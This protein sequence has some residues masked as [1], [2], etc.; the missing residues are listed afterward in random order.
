MFLCQVFNCFFA[1]FKQI[2]VRRKSTEKTI[3][4]QVL[5]AVKVRK[6]TTE[7]R[8]KHKST[9]CLSSNIRP[10]SI[11]R[12]CSNKIPPFD[13]YERIKGH[14]PRWSIHRALL[15]HAPIQKHGLK[16][17][18][19]CRRHV[20]THLWYTP[21]QYTSKYTYLLESIQ[22]TQ[23]QRSGSGLRCKPHESCVLQMYW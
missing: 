10:C 4:C 17:A 12:P 20:S 13:L 22:H 7:K 11:R 1:S 15:Q 6:C 2:S 19:F 23:V 14:A 21:L 16:I 9:Y 8:S 5:C 3:Y 18:V